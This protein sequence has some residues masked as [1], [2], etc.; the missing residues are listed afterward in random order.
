MKLSLYSIIFKDKFID[1]PV[2]GEITCSAY[3]EAFK[4]CSELLDST[5]KLNI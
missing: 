4:R 3:L 1:H 2:L 5:N